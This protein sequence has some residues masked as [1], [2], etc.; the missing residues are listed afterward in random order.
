MSD[1]SSSSSD[2]SI[3]NSPIIIK[4]DGRAKRS[5]KLKMDFFDECLLSTNA[6]A[7]VNRRIA[8]AENNGAASASAVVEAKTDEKVN[9]D[10]D[11]PTRSTEKDEV[12]SEEK[13]SDTEISSSKVHVKQ[14]SDESYWA[15][16]DQFTANNT[17]NN[18]F[19]FHSDRKRLAD[20]VDYDSEA[21]DDEELR[22][23]TSREKRRGEAVAKLTGGQSCLGLRRAFYKKRDNAAAAAA[24]AA[25]HRLSFYIFQSRQEALGDLISIVSVLK[26]ELKKSELTCDKLLHRYFVRPLARLI[27]TSKNVWGRG[28]KSIYG[29][30]KS[31]PVMSGELE[32]AEITC[33]CKDS[34]RCVLMIPDSF[35][36]WMWKMACS[37]LKA[38]SLEHGCARFL[39]RALKKRESNKQE[40]NVCKFVME[41]ETLKKYRMGDLASCLVH[42]FGLR[43]VPGCPSPGESKTESISEKSD[44]QDDSSAFDMSSLQRLFM[45]WTSLLQKDYVLID[46]TDCD[47]GVIGEGATR[48]LV[49]LAIVCL[50]PHLELAAERR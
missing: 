26:Q 6:R 1:D 39:I 8:V 4:K 17:N 18:G 49:A 48:D 50:D 27:K 25:E 40:E 31:N 15:R 10:G 14:E 24:A 37:S 29:F 32:Y 44:D 47:S 2:D 41:S 20:G 5:E 23:E 45:L 16:V 38:S 21:T 30:M 11:I 28:F 42:D 13:K 43:M 7:D 3:L 36:Q 9:D 46:E 35:I 22:N 33:S 34:Q 12:H 19:K